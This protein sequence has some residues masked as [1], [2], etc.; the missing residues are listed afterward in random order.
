MLRKGLGFA[1]NNVIGLLALFVALGGTTYAAARGSTGKLHACVSGDGSVRL[2]KAGKRCA[3]G[4][5]A[6]VWNVKGPAGP[7]GANGPP[8]EG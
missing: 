7:R 4:Q 1:R 5:R 6:V 3:K 8:V 2:V